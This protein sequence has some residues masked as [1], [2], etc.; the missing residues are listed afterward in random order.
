MSNELIKEL[1]SI[2]EEVGFDLGELEE[3]ELIEEGEW[4]SEG[5]YENCES[6]IKYKDKFFCMIQQ[7]SGSYY[8]D[9][10]Y[11]DPFFYEVEPKVI[12]KTI[13]VKVK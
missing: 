4:V 6:I 5:K 1:E 3:V 8:T 9:Y 2:V 7:R 10:Y 12:T 13:Y 11:N